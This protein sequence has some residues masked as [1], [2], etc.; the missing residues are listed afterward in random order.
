ML[1]SREPRKK[2]KDGRTRR[3]RTLRRVRA[4]DLELAKMTEGYMWVVEK[5]GPTCDPDVIGPI[6]GGILQSTYQIRAIDVFCKLFAFFSFKRLTYIYLS[7]Q[8]IN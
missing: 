1:V 4:F 6:E 8:C 7:S 3:D 5:F 2:Y